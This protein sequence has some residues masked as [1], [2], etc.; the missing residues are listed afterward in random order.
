MYLVKILLLKE[1]I[2]VECKLIL[3]TMFFLFLVVFFCF[4]CWL[5]LKWGGWMNEWV[6]KKAKYLCDFFFFRNRG[7]TSTQVKK[8]YW[9]NVKAFLWEYLTSWE[10]I[11]MKI[12]R[13]FF[14][15]FTDVNWTQCMIFLSIFFFF[16]WSG[17]NIYLYW[18]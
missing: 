14:F 5:A 11:H 15:F 16:A 6:S 4:F 10:N 12:F 8:L 13:S 7:A 3:C 9:N 1:T 17:V 2:D 18:F